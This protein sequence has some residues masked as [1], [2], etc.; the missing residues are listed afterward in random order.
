MDSFGAV[1]TGSGPRASGGIMR[2]RSLF[3]VAGSLLFAV[4]GLLPGA[5]AFAHSEALGTTALAATVGT[6][7]PPVTPACISS[8]FGPR[9]LPNHPLAGTF[10]NGIDLPAPAGA[11]VRAIATGR[12]IRAQRHGPGGLE[13]LVQ[14]PGFVGVYSHLGS[15]A[16]A[17]ADGH[18][19]VHA[20]EKIGVVGH[21]GVMYGMHLF[22][23]MELGGHFVDPE[24]YLR[25]ANCHA[26]MRRRSDMMAAD[27]RIP[28]TRSLHLHSVRYAAR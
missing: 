6:L 4:S 8:P 13:L 22:F 15:V 9:T 11:P 17:I 21:S 18:L 16:P 1:L 23:A 14:H 5:Q 10:H 7:E 20:G 19:T 26:G 25:L 3:R 27:G 12:V 28:P 24:H 2:A